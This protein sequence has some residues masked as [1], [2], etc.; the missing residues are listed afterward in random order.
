[1]TASQRVEALSFIWEH[2]CLCLVFGGRP[3]DSGR[4]EHRLCGAKKTCAFLH[5][6]GLEPV[7]ESGAGPAAMAQDMCQHPDRLLQL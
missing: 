2:G 1:M 7:K 4:Q 6:E 5:G 3:W